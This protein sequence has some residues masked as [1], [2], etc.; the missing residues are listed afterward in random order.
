[1]KIKPDTDLHEFFDAI[2][3]CSGS[4]KYCTS[5]GDEIDMKSQLSRYFVTMAFR[6]KGLSVTGNVICTDK[7]DTTHL[8]EFLY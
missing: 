7:K 4:V 6:D 5:E 1:M 3:N 2:D 8:T